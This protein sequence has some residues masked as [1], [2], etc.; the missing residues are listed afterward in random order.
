MPDRG[1][2]PLCADRG[3]YDQIFGGRY[4]YLEIYYFGIRL[5]AA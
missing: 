3:A 5:G 1:D 4:P 2:L